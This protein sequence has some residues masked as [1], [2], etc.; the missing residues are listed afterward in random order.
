MTVELEGKVALVTGAG[1]G[2]GRACALRLAREGGEVGGNDRD[3]GRAAAVGCEVEAL[4]RR[5]V[6]LPADVGDEAQVEAMVAR[7]VTVL[8]GLDILVNN[9]GLVRASLAE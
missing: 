3:A 2:I 5:A 1:Q 8:G 9:A 7:V 6:A 4:G